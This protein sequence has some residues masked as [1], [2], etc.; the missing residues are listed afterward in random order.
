[1]ISEFN[2]DKRK[3]KRKKKKNETVVSNHITHKS[4]RFFSLPNASGIV[5]VKLF[6]E[7]SLHKHSKLK[8]VRYAR[9]K[10]YEIID[11]KCIMQK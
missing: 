8:K 5:P 4:V 2:I 9:E 1:M 6:A 3:K 7:R 10:Q 11:K